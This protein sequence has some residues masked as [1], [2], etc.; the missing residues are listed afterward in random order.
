MSGRR[1]WNKGARTERAMVRPLV[2]HSLPARKVSAMYKRG[3]ETADRRRADDEELKSLDNSKDDDDPDVRVVG[4]DVERSVGVK[5]L[6]ADWLDGRDLL[7][8]KADRQKAL[9]VLRMSLATEIAKGT[10]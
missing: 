5:F 6:A 2:G 9:V 3:E 10:A 7:I 1:S 4:G 8:V